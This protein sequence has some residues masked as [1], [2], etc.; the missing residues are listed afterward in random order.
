M[1]S[2]LWPIVG[3]AL[4]WAAALLYWVLV[5]GES[6]V[7]P[8]I[9]FGVFALGFP[10]LTYLLLTG[11]DPLPTTE[12]TS[13]L[14]PYALAFLLAAIVAY[15][16]YGP[17]YV[18]GFVETRAPNSEIALL[19][20]QAAGKLAVFVLLPILLM[21]WIIRHP[22]SSFG[23]HSPSRRMVGAR[24]LL[25]FFVI[26]VG[27]SVFQYFLGADSESIREGAFTREQMFVGMPITFGWLVISAGL[28]EEFFFR[29]V[30]QSRLAMLLR[31]EWSAMFIASLAFALVHVPGIVLRGNEAG[32]PALMTVSAILLLSATSI[33]FGFIWMRTR[34]LLILILLH[35]AGDLL[36]SYVALSEIFGLA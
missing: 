22:M 3:Y 1:R 25:L 27:L 35:A 26:G 29:G 4:I 17:E 20:G 33:T 10:A 8:V 11:D 28:V 9:M 30:L 36:P 21:S 13:W 7:E 6:Y 12:E 31:N 5:A 18:A 24:H 32:D 19:I 2:F 23:W 34:N 14:E 15:L 16:I